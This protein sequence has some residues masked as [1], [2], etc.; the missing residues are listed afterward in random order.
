MKVTPIVFDAAPIATKSVLPTKT[1]VYESP[2]TNDPARVNPVDDAVNIVPT[3]FELAPNKVK[4]VVPNVVI[5]YCCP[6][7]KDPA[8]VTGLAFIVAVYSV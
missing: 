8:G 5:S 3:V 1:I 7:I 4:S 6:I 2:I